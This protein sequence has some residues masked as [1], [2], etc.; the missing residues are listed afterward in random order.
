MSYAF[1]HKCCT[2][3]PSIV[4]L[5]VVL[6]QVL[7]YITAESERASLLGYDQGT[8]GADQ[9][10]AGMLLD[11]QPKYTANSNVILMCMCSCI[12]HI[13]N[14]DDVHVWCCHSSLVYL[15]EAPPVWLHRYHMYYNISSHLVQQTFCLR[16]D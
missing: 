10:E 8:Q 7:F 2:V 14:T 3:I 16:S 6:L 4:F 1:V 12:S 15:V 11:Y 9:P 5:Q 13:L